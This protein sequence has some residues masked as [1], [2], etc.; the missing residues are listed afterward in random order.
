MKL[1]RKQKRAENKRRHR[2]LKRMKVVTYDDLI[3]R[4]RNPLVRFKARGKRV[5][6]YARRRARGPVPKHLRRYTFKRR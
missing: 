3:A 1:T 5:S 4:D 6:F 2:A